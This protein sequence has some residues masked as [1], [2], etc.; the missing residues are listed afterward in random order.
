MVLEFSCFEQ[1]VSCLVVV[2]FMQSNIFSFPTDEHPKYG[3]N[4][5]DFNLKDIAGVCSFS[6]YA[7]NRGSKL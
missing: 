4:L 5:E 3:V 6:W 7:K 2:D 1:L